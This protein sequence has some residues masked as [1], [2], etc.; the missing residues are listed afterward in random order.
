M[1]VNGSRTSLAVADHSAKP[2]HGV[3]RES[4]YVR[5]ST[6]RESSDDSDADRR[7]SSASRKSRT[8]S[9]RSTSASG[10]RVSI[11]HA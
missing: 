4:S 5:R 11:T 10:R 8:K 6:Q 2:D 1:E 7:R 3:H 9:G